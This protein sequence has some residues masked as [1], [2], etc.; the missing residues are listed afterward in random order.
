MLAAGSAAALADAVAGLEVDTGAL[1]R[2][3]TAAEIGSDTGEA[4]AFVRAIL[5]DHREKA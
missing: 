2:N 1:Q 4:E 3:L 5:D